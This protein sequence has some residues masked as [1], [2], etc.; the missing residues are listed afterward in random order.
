MNTILHRASTQQTD[1][2]SALMAFL[3]FVGSQDHSAGSESAIA[4]VSSEAQFLVGSVA[5]LDP[6]VVADAFEAECFTSV[7]SLRWIATSGSK[8]FTGIATLISESASGFPL[9]WTAEAVPCFATSSTYPCWGDVLEVDAEGPLVGDDARQFKILDAGM[10]PRAGD[11][12]S[13][14]AV[15][16]SRADEWGNHCV[17]EERL[18]K[19]HND[20]GTQS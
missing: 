8:P 4:M 1:L 19:F 5:K 17:F 9:E 20:G 6:S 14:H 2:A 10:R 18:V 3:S 11:R 16:Y 7:L 15:E 13:L 12:L